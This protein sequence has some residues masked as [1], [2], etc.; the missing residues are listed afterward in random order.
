MKRLDFSLKVFIT[1]I[2]LCISGIVFSTIAI[3]K[4]I[5][6]YIDEMKTEIK[7]VNNTDDDVLITRE[8]NNIIITIDK[9]TQPEE[10]TEKE[11]DI[12]I[13]T[14]ISGLNIRRDASVESERIDILEYGERIEIL[15]D[16]GDWYRIENGYIF[17]DYVIKI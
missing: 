7:I 16:C 11:N 13:V 1:L 5:D 14:S 12:G 6:S 17:K 9:P 3:D 4:Q 8:D 15:E 2:V 10:V